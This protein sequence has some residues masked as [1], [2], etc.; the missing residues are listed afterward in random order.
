MKIKFLSAL[1]AVLMVLA[2]LASAIVPAFAA[3]EE[4]DDEEKEIDEIIAEHLTKTYSSPQSKLAVMTKKLDKNGYELWV[5]PETGEIAFVSK[6]SGQ[7][8]FSNPWNI[9]SGTESEPMKK[10]IMSQIFINYNNN[11]Q[12]ATMNSFEEAAQ[13]GQI[14]VK[15]IKNGVRVEYTIGREE[16]RLLVPRYIKESRFL[17]E[18]AKPIFDG[19]LADGIIKGDKLSSQDFTDYVYN[20]KSIRTKDTFP[21][22]YYIK[23]L[24][25][26]N[27]KDP[28]EEGISPQLQ[29]TIY[30]TWP[31]TKKIGG[32]FVIAAD[33][34]TNELRS[35]E[36]TIKQYCPEYTYEQLDNDHVEC[37]YEGTDKAPP[38]F[39]MA[40]EYT[41]DD[42]GLQVTL[43][44]SGIRFNESLY[45]LDNIEVLPYMGAGSNPNS[46]YT[47]FPDGS[48]A[49]FDFEKLDTKQKVTISGKVYGPDF[50]YHTITGTHQEI[51][52][53]PVFGIVENFKQG[54]LVV[55]PPSSSESG[56]GTT[57]EGE[58]TAQDTTAATT[59][60][61]APETS[62]G[63]DG[64]TSGEGGGIQVPTVGSIVSNGILCVIEEGDALAT[65]TTSHGGATSRY[66]T[67]KM[68][69]AP[70]PKDT[71]DLSGSL[72]V[73]TGSTW[74]VV[75]KRKYVGNY[76]IRY[77]MMTDQNIAE[78]KGLENTFEPTWMGMARAYSAYLV[79][80]GVLKRLTED[81]VKENIPL[82][83]ETFGTLETLEKIL[84]VPVNVMTPLTSFED[85]KSMYDELSSNGV[86]N[87][88]FKLKGYAN[89]GIYSGIPADVKWEKAV[90]GDDGFKDLVSYAKEKGFNVFP[91][92]D[93]VFVNSSTNTMF[94]ALN[95]KKHTVKTIDGR[96][97]SK[98]EYSAT[99]QSY[100]S[101]YELALS[102]E[103]FMHFYNKLTENYSVYDNSSISV[104]TLG[105]YLN[106]NFDEDAPLNREDSKDYTVKIFQQLQEDYANVMTDSGN[107]YTWSYV[108]YIL[109]VP[110]SSSRYIKSSNTVPFMGVVLHG[111]VQFAGTPTN[112]EG[113][114]SYAFLKAIE[115]GSGIYFKLVY[116]NAEKLKEYDQ[117]SQNFSVRYD[118]WKN[119]LIVMYNQLNEILAD[120]QLSTIVGHEFLVGNRIPTESEKLEDAA[121]KAEKEEAD[122]LQ[123]EAD[124]KAQEIKD[125]YEGRVNALIKATEYL[126]RL[127]ISATAITDPET[128]YYSKLV[129]AM[130]HLPIVEK[131]AKD[132]EAM[133]PEVDKLQKEYDDLVAAKKTAEAEAKKLELDAILVKYNALCNIPEFKK[134]DGTDE[135]P[136]LAAEGDAFEKLSSLANTISISIRSHA[137]NM[138]NT[139]K[140]LFSNA[141]IIDEQLRL[142]EAAASYFTV[143]NGF[144]ADLEKELQDNL[145]AVKEVQATAI[146]AINEAYND[147]L[148]AHQDA[149]KYIYEEGTP[150]EEKRTIQT[151]EEYKKEQAANA[152]TNKPET[153]T[154]AE[155]NRYLE[156]SGNIILL[157]YENGK[158]IILNYNYFDVTVEVNGKTYTVEKCDFNYETRKYSGYLVINEGGAN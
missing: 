37:Q 53:Y 89:G 11:G 130:N 29:T 86:S 7:I 65:I 145:K 150:A 103:Y 151:Y 114:I 20:R 115:N 64:S 127:N 119:D 134:A 154:G 137:N 10:E 106:S 126:S 122:K 54:E 1:L 148:K 117:L 48:G 98:R 110:I 75:S 131:A 80:K 109:N 121:N 15:N 12:A 140:G 2:A 18:I 153:N 118:I 68:S 70:R 88:N 3:D 60:T 138:Y 128:G 47:L 36:Q 13:R 16:T 32:I 83:I 116:Q 105:S 91:D 42:W 141:L 97:T 96:Y 132:A 8:T 107:Y 129:T 23:F 21:A 43:P 152:G 61:Q 93:F 28:N 66:N 143:K 82:Y 113:N 52:R 67:V 144:S 14:V 102:P 45:K 136:E 77:I 85:V 125:R 90:G 49:L 81:D 124:K 84:S 135:Y 149:D 55:T 74:D 120:V 112:M 4:K 146:A 30:Q 72:A 26:Y 142:A 46:G 50:A 22:F 157:T 104:S 5:L 73:G 33:V 17:S 19:M 44:A 57:A 79:D 78:E 58:T 56:E 39:K 71:Y 27:L 147:V 156:D 24:S 25:L 63:T 158:Q 41:M 99:Y 69:F 139:Y 59:E 133:K 35:H 101:Y 34:S 76:K 155:D 9:A 6:A 94:D 92:F 87:I 31:A 40:L 108:D 62:T 38:L 111:F 95:L 51:I 123:E 100:I